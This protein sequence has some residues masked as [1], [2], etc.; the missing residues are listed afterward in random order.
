[1]RHVVGHDYDAIR[2]LCLFNNLLHKKLLAKYSKDNAANFIKNNL[3]DV[4]S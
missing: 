3:M 1:M 4:P 2:K